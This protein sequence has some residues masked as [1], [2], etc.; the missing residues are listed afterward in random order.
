[1]QLSLHAPLPPHIALLIRPRI[2]INL[3]TPTGPDFYRLY[4]LIVPPTIQLAFPFSIERLFHVSCR[5]ILSKVLKN[6][7]A[8]VSLDGV[9]LMSRIIIRILIEATLFPTSIVKSFFE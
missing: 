3:D 2:E 4:C 9:G 5:R 7:N 8:L 1:M 6:K